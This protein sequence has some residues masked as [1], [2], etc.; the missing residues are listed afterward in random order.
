M[1][2]RLKNLAHR[3]E[4]FLANVR[5]GWPSRRLRVV[6]ITG[7]DGKTTTATILYRILEQAGEPVAAITTIGAMIRGRV[8]PIGFHV[9]TPAPFS[10]QRHLRHVVDAGCRTLVLEVTSHALDQHRADGIRFDLGVLTN[11]TH[12]HLDYHRTYAAYVRAKLRLLRAARVAIINRDDGSYD[13]V[14]PSLGGKRII[15]YSLTNDDADVTLR[16]FPFETT[17]EGDYN[18]QNCLAA[19]AAARELGVDDEVIRRVVATFTPP[20]GRQEVVEQGAFTVVIDFAHT[21]NA[22]AVALPPLRRRA[23]LH[24]LIHVFGAAGLRDAS[25]RPIMGRESARS[26]DVIILT[27]EDPRTESIRDIN[28]QIRTG[29]SG[30]TELARPGPGG[31]GR[32][33]RGRTRP[34]RRGCGATCARWC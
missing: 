12:E 8:S 20:I 16:S 9:T 13:H 3:V 21:P 27:A 19:I 10:L 2:R 17:L 15:R 5:F 28:R 14:R 30:F 24:R 25:K 22:F 26:A 33:S 11:I 18:R 7:T 31:P 29:I 6:G 4:A 34:H 32:G 1:L 23:G